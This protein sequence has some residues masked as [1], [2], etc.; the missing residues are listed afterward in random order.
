MDS[1]ALVYIVLTILAMGFALLTNASP[2]SLT[3]SDPRWSRQKLRNHTATFAIFCLLAGVSACRIAV[4]NDYWVY[5]FNFELIAQNRHVSSEIGFNAIVW[6]MQDLFGYGNYLPIFALFSLVTVF[7]FMKALL[8]LSDFFAASLYLLLT[9][10]YYFSSLNN[11]RYYLALAMALWSMYFCLRKQYVQ[12]LAVVF[13]AS[14]FHKTVLLVIPVYLVA[15]WLAETTFRIWHAVL[16]GLFTVS[17]ILAS[18]LYE[19]LMF[20]IYPFYQ[21]SDFVPSGISWTNVAKCAGTLIL[22]LFVYGKRIL[23][24]DRKGKFYFILTVGGLILYLCASYI[25]EISRI[26]FYL[27][28]SQIFWIPKLL[29][30]IPKTGLRIFCTVGVALAYWGYFMIF[31]VQSYDTNIRLL[32]YR[33]W[34]FQ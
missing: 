15:M 3:N 25:P 11:I 23:T 10:G 32:P 12:F 30:E 6:L 2:A 33:N 29:M 28:A 20:W 14:F 18:P 26:G 16:L 34:I 24:I 22:A 17:L 4:G 7:F 31:L 13:M 19:K 1:S 5:R 27:I 8:G 9:S 21:N